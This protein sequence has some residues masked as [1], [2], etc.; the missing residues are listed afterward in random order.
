MQLI[1][2]RQHVFP[3][4][5]DF[6]IGVR[7]ELLRRAAKYRPWTSAQCTCSSQ[8]DVRLVHLD[9]CSQDSGGGGIVL[10]HFRCHL[11]G[12]LLPVLVRALDEKFKRM[13]EKIIALPAAS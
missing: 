11:E 4:G 12:D 5:G 6:R 9:E 1:D 10:V 3:D 2:S 8:P 13:L 7:R